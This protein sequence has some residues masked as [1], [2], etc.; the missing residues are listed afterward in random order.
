MIKEGHDSINMKIKNRMMT[1]LNNI[2]SSIQ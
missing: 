1:R 2:I